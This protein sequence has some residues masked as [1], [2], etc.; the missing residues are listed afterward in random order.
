MFPQYVNGCSR[1]VEERN[2]Y[3]E[4]NSH[5]SYVYRVGIKCAPESGIRT[6]TIPYASVH[7]DSFHKQLER[8]EDIPFMHIL[9]TH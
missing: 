2:V 4:E 7:I 5:E 8:K 3:K 6:H 1:L 9:N